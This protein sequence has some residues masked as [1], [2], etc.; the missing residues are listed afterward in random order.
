MFLFLALFAP[1]TVLCQNN[2]TGPSGDAYNIS[3]PENPYKVEQHGTIFFWGLTFAC[4][5]I[6]YEQM[7]HNEEFTEWNTKILTTLKSNTNIITIEMTRLA[8][9]LKKQKRDDDK[10]AMNALAISQLR[11]NPPVFNINPALPLDCKDERG[12][13]I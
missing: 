7:E 10:Y 5:F 6:I 8:K 1:F 13:K 4:I 3:S 2:T 9:R 12:P 11:S